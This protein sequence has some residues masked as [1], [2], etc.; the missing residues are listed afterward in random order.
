MLYNYLHEWVFPFKIAGPSFSELELDNRTS[1]S[2]FSMF[3]VMASN[4]PAYVGPSTSGV[5]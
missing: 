1:T 4:L 3:A 2:T 5:G